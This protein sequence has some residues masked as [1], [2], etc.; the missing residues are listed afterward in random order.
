M[1]IRRRKNFRN[2]VSGQQRPEL[3]LVTVM[4]PAVMFP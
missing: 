3:G 2:Q 1:V 4:T